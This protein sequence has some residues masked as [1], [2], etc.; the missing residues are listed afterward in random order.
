[1]GRYYIRGNSTVLFFWREQF[2]K[3]FASHDM[4]QK[5]ASLK[6]GMDDISVKYID[7]FMRLS[8]YWYKSTCVGSQWTEH[9][10]KKQVECQEFA[11][12]L[13]QPFPDILKVNPYYFYDIYGLADLPQ[14]ALASI[15]GKVII[16]GGGLNGDTA[17]VFNRHFPNSEIHVYEPLE[18]YVNIIKRFLEVD[19]CNNKIIPV[20]KGLGDEITKRFIRFGA[21]ANMADIT[22]IDSEYQD[23][24]KPVGLIKLD[25]EGME[26]NI[27]KGAAKLIAK[28]KPVLA[29]AIYHSPEDFFEL[30]NKIK[31]MNQ[32]YMFMIRK[33]DLTL[34]QSGFVLLAY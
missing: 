18:H 3:Y 21:G 25:T 26:T 6:D 9:D 14:E 20:N 15:D 22:T 34:P 13:V 12:T 17:L 24:D 4:R 33:S 2:T 23:N 32:S 30:R 5:L 10:L 28:D 1:M 11:K 8:R 29:I 16:D 31:N 27:I 7:N 19:E